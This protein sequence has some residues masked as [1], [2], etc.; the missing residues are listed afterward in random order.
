MNIISD[1]MRVIVHNYIK[2]AG[3]QGNPVKRTVTLL[4][5]KMTHDLKILSNMTELLETNRMETIALMFG[6]TLD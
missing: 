1:S 5:N 2:L 4:S 6:A 3:V